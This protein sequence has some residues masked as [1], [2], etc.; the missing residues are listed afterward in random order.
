MSESSSNATRVPRDVTEEDGWCLEKRRWAFHRSAFRALGRPRGEP[1]R[2]R[3]LESIRRH[4][5][6]EARPGDH[7]GD[8][9]RRGRDTDKP[10]RT[11]WR[12]AER[13][14]ADRGRRYRVE[15]PRCVL[16]RAERSGI[17]KPSLRQRTKSF[18][19]LDRAAD[20]IFVSPSWTC[21]PPAE[22][23]RLQQPA[24]PSETP[25]ASTSPQ[26]RPASLETVGGSLD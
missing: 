26:H 2:L 24:G 23:A 1:S 16:R 21:Q 5:A 4:V 7:A 17:W 8:P 10:R 18:Q 13:Q 3:R 6:V 20:D 11:K 14:P 19:C 12:R 22:P 25:L 15:C 9:W